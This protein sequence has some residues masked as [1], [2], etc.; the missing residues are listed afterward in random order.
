[1]CTGLKLALPVLHP[2]YNLYGATGITGSMHQT[3]I[4]TL[5]DFGCSM[6]KTHTKNNA[7]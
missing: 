3:Q 5:W 7:L 2:G 6:N 1:M 4:K